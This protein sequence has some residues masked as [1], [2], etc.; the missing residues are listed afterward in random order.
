MN[1]RKRHLAVDLGGLPVM[2]MVAPAGRA[3]RDAARDL[4]VACALRHSQGAEIGDPGKPVAV[5]PL[6]A[7]TSVQPTG[8]TG[9]AS[10]DLANDSGCSSCGEPGVVPGVETGAQGM[11]AR[12]AASGVLP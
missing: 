9:K 8:R 11:D 4:L 1:G 10:G 6:E 5:R 12:V 2:I 3:D 7:P